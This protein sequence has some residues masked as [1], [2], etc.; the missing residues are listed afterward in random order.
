MFS[1]VIIFYDE[2]NIQGFKNTCTVLIPLK[3][4]RIYVPNVHKSGKKCA[5]I[6]ILAQ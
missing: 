6:A 3:H 4:K 2:T 5:S 1:F